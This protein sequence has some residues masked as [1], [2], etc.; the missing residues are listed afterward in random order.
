VKEM[1]ARVDAVFKVTVRTVRETIPKL[2]G[3]FLVR[4]SQD[5][6]S[7]ELHMRVNENEGLL[8]CLGEPKQITERR[9][10][11]SETIRV[12]KESLKVLQR[13]PE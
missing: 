10:T 8:D 5:K 7:S 3:Y 1:R 9:A 4:M 6:L 11:L 2:I 13:D 12:L